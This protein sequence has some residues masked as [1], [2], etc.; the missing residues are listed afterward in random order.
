VCVCV[1]MRGLAPMHIAFPKQKKFVFQII[2]K[3]KLIR[4]QHPLVKSHVD[5]Y[6]I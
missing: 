3:Q 5:R 1:F 4:L 2:L 6:S